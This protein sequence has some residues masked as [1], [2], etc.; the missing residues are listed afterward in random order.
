MGSWEL[1]VLMAVANAECTAATETVTDR[2]K[3]CGE[4]T[5]GSWPLTETVT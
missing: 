5:K 3:Q 4:V 1:S 2:L